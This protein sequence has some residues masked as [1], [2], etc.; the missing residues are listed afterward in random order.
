MGLCRPFRKEPKVLEENIASIFSLLSW[1]Q[2]LPISCLAYSSTLKTGAICSSETSGFLRTTR[3]Y[4]AEDRT[5]HNHR[6]EN[7]RS[8]M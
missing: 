5:L 2:I 1:R 7:L 8:N 6:R 3:R 4:N